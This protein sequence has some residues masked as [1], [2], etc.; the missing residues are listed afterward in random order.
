MARKIAIVGVGKIARD[1]HIP[2]ITNSPD[3]ELA[4][5]VSRNTAVEGVPNYYDLDTLLTTHP[6][7]G[8]VSLCMPPLPRFEIAAAA[9]SAGKHV[10]LEKPPGATLSEVNTL[11]DMAASRGLTLYATWHSRE[12]EQVPAA[13]AWLKD[14]RIHRFTVTW[15]ENV[16]KWHPGQDWVFEPGGMGVFDPGINALSIVTEILPDPIHLSSA[17]LAFPENRDTPIAARLEFF[18]P[19][20]A[21]VSADMDWREEGADIWDI[22]AETDGGTLQLRH[23]GGT[24]LIDGIEQPGLGVALG[25]EYPNLYAKMSNLI[26]EGISDIDLRPMI[27]VTDALSLGKREFVDPFHF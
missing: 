27:H 8:V 12:A 26:D 24:L 7:I 16:R 25:G 22:T 4:A 2:A 5:A 18:H 6:E 3:W 23:G 9:L 14:K 17:V 13:K 15:R 11:A 19:H 1:Q 10:M 20:G 21:V